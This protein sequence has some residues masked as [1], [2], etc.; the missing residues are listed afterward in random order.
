MA[1]IQ[2]SLRRLILTLYCLAARVIT[3]TLPRRWWYSAAFRLSCAQVMALRPLAFLGVYPYRRD[4]RD[5][6]KRRR[7]IQSRMMVRW[8]DTLGLSGKA[9]P[10]PFRMRGEEVF[11]QAMARG[12]GL[13]VG[14]AHLFLIRCAVLALA[15]MLPQAETM[16]VAS[17]NAIEDE[18]V[19]LWNQPVRLAAVAIGDSPLLKLRTLLRAGGIAPVLMDRVMGSELDAKILRLV[20]A[21]GAQLLLSTVELQ[22][23]GEVLIEVFS[24]PDPDCQTEESIHANLEALRLRRDAILQISS[25]PV[26]PLPESAAATRSEARQARTAVQPVPELR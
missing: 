4:I 6:E 12:Q 19:P 9:F 22:S 24:P 11:W 13:V 23:N 26:R 7:V 5:W 21:V 18:A 16:T 2:R 25:A 15:R 14:S 10:I 8:L 20:R 1:S 17:P 3:A